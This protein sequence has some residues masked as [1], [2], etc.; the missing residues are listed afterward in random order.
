[1]MNKTTDKKEGS[2]KRAGKSRRRKGLVY[3]L[4]AG[5][6]VSD[7]LFLGLFLGF[8]LALPLA[9]FGA[10]AIS[11]E[12]S[13]VL[14]VAG[15][16]LLFLCIA[17]VVATGYRKRIQ[18]ALF[19]EDIKGTL[20]EVGERLVL[21]LRK[22]AEGDEQGIRDHVGYV[23]REVAAVYSWVSLRRLMLATVGAACAAFL[24]LVGSYL[25]IRQT[26]AVEEQNKVIATQSS[27]LELQ[28]KA[29][30]EAHRLSAIRQRNATLGEAIYGENATERRRA[31]L[32]LAQY[33]RPVYVGVDMRHKLYNTDGGF[34]RRDRS[35]D[36]IFLSGTEALR[37]CVFV[38]ADITWYARQDGG[39][40]EG[41]SLESVNFSIHLSGQQGVTKARFEQC[42]LEW[43][44]VAGGQLELVAGTYASSS[45]ITAKVAHIAG[46]VF[47]ESTLVA[48]AMG[49]NRGTFD[50]CFVVVGDPP[51]AWHPKKDF[52][53]KDSPWFGDRHSL[54]GG[55]ERWGMGVVEEEVLSR[56]DNASSP[57]WRW[58]THDS[59]FVDATFAHSVLV[60]ARRTINRVEP[61]RVRVSAS[62]FRENTVVVCKQTNAVHF[63]N[64]GFAGT[65]LTVEPGAD[66]SL[67]NCRGRIQVSGQVNEGWRQQA[68]KASPNLVIE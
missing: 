40:V 68:A 59:G 64:C 55:M 58:G 13:T 48:E 32:E 67:E 62:E 21:A 22:S 35:V 9:L 19:G 61:F 41:C 29:Q 11:D 39:L 12:I 26:E 4:L 10:D 1:M 47:S 15:A 46:A 34:S 7:R 56:F 31:A 20:N 3:S 42:H 14:A 30:Q 36:L 44:R 53:M 23:T 24:G 33:D 27:I 28:L 60:F 25:V 50:G 52:D 49:C 18:A 5:A 66:V 2:S 54:P 38:D 16:L 57:D 65:R 8:A 63:A 17:A 51:G 45:D 37:A 6:K 43:A